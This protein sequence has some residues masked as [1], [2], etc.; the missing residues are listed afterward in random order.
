ME[1][2]VEQKTMK[3]SEF[4]YCKTSISYHF[5]KKEEYYIQCSL[6][7]QGGS[8]PIQSSLPLMESQYNQFHRN[9]H[10]PHN[11]QPAAITKK[12]VSTQTIPYPY[13]LVNFEKPLS[14]SLL[15]RKKSMFDHGILAGKLLEHQ[16]EIHYMLPVQCKNHQFTDQSFSILV[17]WVS[18]V[19]KQNIDL[20]PVCWQ[21]FGSFSLFLNDNISKH[22]HVNMRNL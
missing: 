10:C 8:I 1:Y 6:K 2:P 9:R 11:T 12:N 14:V 13:H 18:P 20:I 22:V 7:T 3:Q 17:P 21:K 16:N 19:H 15:L 5:I 4:W